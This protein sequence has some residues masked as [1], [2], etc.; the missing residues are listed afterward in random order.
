MAILGKERD[1]RIVHED[2]V[3]D[4]RFGRSGVGALLEHVGV[5]RLHDLD[6][7]AL[8]F[9]LV[10]RGGSQS[11]A[12]A[13]GWYEDREVGQC[14][15]VAIS[16]DNA[17]T[18]KLETCATF[19]SSIAEPYTP[20]RTTHVMRTLTRRMLAWQLNL[21]E[22][23]PAETDAAPWNL[24]CNSQ[25]IG[26]STR[27]GSVESPF[28]GNFASP[29]AEPDAPRTNWRCAASSVRSRRVP[30]GACPPPLKNRSSIGHLG[31]L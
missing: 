20:S 19:A 1:P 7:A 2:D 22:F 24:H 8:H 9:R 25:S 18:L 23:R 30:V 3:E 28:V 31:L 14:G 15:S 29:C 21:L 26:M 17:K 10:G 27:C 11:I 5:G 13:A 16:D 12:L 4:T 6:L